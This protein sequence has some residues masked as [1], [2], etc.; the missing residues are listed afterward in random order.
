MST[1]KC[2][3]CGF[4][5]WITSPACKKCGAINPDAPLEAIL[6]HSSAPDKTEKKPFQKSDQS[7]I[8][9]RSS[10]AA[11]THLSI[12]KPGESAAQMS[13]FLAGSAHQGEASSEKLK[14]IAKVRSLAVEVECDQRDEPSVRSLEYQ[15][16]MAVAERR[17]QY[18]WMCGIAICLGSAALLSVESAMKTLDMGT[19]TAMF[20]EIGIFALL[21]IG[22]YCRW[23]VCSVAL[24]VLFILDKIVT[25]A[26]TRNYVIGF[27][28]LLL[29]YVLFLG[30]RGTSTYHRLAE[31]Y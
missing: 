19:K 29:A 2:S 8:A 5:D 13:A 25:V 15:S 20:I 10:F 11:P 18:A 12:P 17:I 23:R 26:Q 7:A 9:H 27:V 4:L 30:V 24:F 21:T 22:V 16:E 28:A 1:Y 31:N 3:Q 14:T 6:H